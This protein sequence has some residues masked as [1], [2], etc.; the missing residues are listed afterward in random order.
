MNEVV[1]GCY[2]DAVPVVKM[3]LSVVGAV[4]YMSPSII[5]DKNKNTKHVYTIQ[6]D[7]WALGILA[8]F[9]GAGD[10]PSS[11]AKLMNES[12]SK[13]CLSCFEGKDL[14]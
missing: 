7:I 13:F 5:S 8:Y 2:D 10:F 9:I 12:I 11:G 4:Q 3:P 1:L 14:A 6:D